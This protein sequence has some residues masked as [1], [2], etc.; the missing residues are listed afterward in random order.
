MTLVAGGIAYYTA[1][2][3]E[4]NMDETEV[5]KSADRVRD[6]TRMTN[7]TR[8]GDG[9]YLCPKCVK[10]QRR[11]FRR[12]IRKFTKKKSLLLI[13]Y[14]ILAAVACVIFW[15]ILDFVNNADF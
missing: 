1:I 12:I 14:M 13:F 2:E 7:A 4:W 11:S 3:M 8:A 15:M 10:V 5:K 9:T 6:V